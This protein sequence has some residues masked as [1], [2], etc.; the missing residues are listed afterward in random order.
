MALP[1]HGAS[2]NVSEDFL[3]AVKASY[4]VASADRH[5]NLRH[6][7]SRTMQCVASRGAS[8]SLATGRRPSIRCEAVG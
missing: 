3:K 6:P 7:G 1:H 8:F 5:G 4:C 2:G